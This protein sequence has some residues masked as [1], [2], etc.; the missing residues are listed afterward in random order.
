MLDI[1]GSTDVE[2]PILVAWGETNVHVVT[3]ISDEG[4]LVATPSQAQGLAPVLNR[5][6]PQV[7]S[8]GDLSSALSGA[9]NDE[10]VQIRLPEITVPMVAARLVTETDLPVPRRTVV[11]QPSLRRPVSQ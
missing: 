8:A 7:V 5:L 11:L 2:A 10:P 3:E 1:V 6:P 4:T 9:A